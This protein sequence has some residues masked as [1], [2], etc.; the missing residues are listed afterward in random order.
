MPK[1]AKPSSCAAA[2][3]AKAST[4]ASYGKASV[5]PC[6]LRHTFAHPALLNRVCDRLR[7]RVLINVAHATLVARQRAA[8]LA[9]TMECS[10]A[11]LVCLAL[12]F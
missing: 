11:I 6:L 5:P 2:H 9:N 8:T 3:S 7:G 4:S 1:P 12:S 10:G